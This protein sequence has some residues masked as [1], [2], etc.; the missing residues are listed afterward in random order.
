VSN[1]IN[2]AIST[3]Q[4]NVERQISDSST[5]E[6]TKSLIL[7]ITKEIEKLAKA[8]SDATD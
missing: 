1:Q 5:D 2:N 4:R 6:Q 8:I 7:N 3:F